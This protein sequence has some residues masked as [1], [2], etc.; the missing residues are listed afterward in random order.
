MLM[1]PPLTPLEGVRFNVEVS[2]EGPDEVIVG[3]TLR[4]LLI[5]FYDVEGTGG[6]AER[7]ESSNPQLPYIVRTNNVDT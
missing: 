1:M 5:N 2:E 6:S 4:F 7:L 3:E